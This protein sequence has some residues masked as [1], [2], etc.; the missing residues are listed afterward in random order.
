MDKKD[1]II[2]QLSRTKN[3][4]YEAYVVSR[5]IH[6][7]ND[8]NIK[9]VT[10]QHVTRLEG[11]ALTDLFFPQFSLHVE[12]DEAHHLNP[13][14]TQNDKVREA[15]IVNATGHEICRI[16]AT[17]SLDSI[18]IQIDEVVNRLRVLRED[19]TF[20]PWDM[21]AEFKAE[22]YIKRGYIDTK[23]NV[24]FK[25]IREA[26]NCFGHNYKGFQRAGASHP[27]PDIMLWFPKL[28]PNG[29]WNNQISK[30]EN[31]ITERHED[32]DD[33]RLHVSMHLD[34]SNNRKHQRI[35]F[36]KV[37]GN[38]GDVL[39]RFRGHYKLDTEKSNEEQ[40]LIWRRVSTRVATYQ[41]T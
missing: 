20:I 37:R 30:D 4:K 11:R 2:R 10:Q 33:A 29:K 34:T 3:K 26:C 27:D 1:Y 18:N 22:T 38:L 12:I 23:D 21:E 6:L 32:D 31:V 7:L 40:G 35:V 8:F 9:F 5:I 28:F 17:E 36:A 14:N 39:Y 19:N 15:D 25:T 13:E 24:A 41:H 16:D